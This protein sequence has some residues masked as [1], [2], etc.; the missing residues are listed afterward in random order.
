MIVFMGKN[1]AKGIPV[2]PATG[3]TGAG[4]ILDATS[5]PPKGL[6][7]GG[8]VIKIQQS[9]IAPPY[10]GRSPKADLLINPKVS[11]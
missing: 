6:P 2:I 7:H 3:D 9:F 1:A 8:L 4:F 10:L 11:R 5:P